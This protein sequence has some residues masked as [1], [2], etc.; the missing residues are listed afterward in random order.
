MKSKVQLFCYTYAGGN[1]SFFDEIEK[2]LPKIECVKPE[3]SGHGTRHREPFY[4][5]FDEL[6][7][8][9]Y[10]LF[11]QAYK[12]GD[13]A[14]FGYS[15]G[16]ISLVEVL[17]RI[18]NAG[19]I[20]E[21]KRV[22][23]AAHDPQNRVVPFKADDETLTEWV[24]QRTIQFGAVPEKLINNKT[25][26]RTYLPLYAADY[27]IIG[28]Y[29]FE[30]LK[31]RITVPATVFYSEKDTPLSEMKLWEKFFQCEYCQFDGTHFFIQEHHEEMAG[32]IRS[33]LC[34]EG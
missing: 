34:M 27:S 13:Y 23:L 18:C 28:K 8:D 31:L 11:R 3:Y 33:R 10:M 2:E 12:G 5:D 6:A 16:T 17:K 21:P 1:C 32:I 29:R 25:Y 14:L 22:F 15:M 20:P 24:K 4:H 26:W 30:N 9:M 19:D 7:D